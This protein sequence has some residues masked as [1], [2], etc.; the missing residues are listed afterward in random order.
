[1]NGS[2]IDPSP[3]RSATQDEVLDLDT[4]ELIGG[5]LVDVDGLSSSRPRGKQSEAHSTMQR[6]VEGLVEK[7]RCLYN[8]MIKK[9]ELDE[10]HEDDTSFVRSTAKSLFSDGT[11]SWCRITSLVAL[12]AVVCQYLRKKNREQCV[13]SVGHEIST[14]LL[15]EQREWL[16]ENNSWDGFVDF[17]RV[18]DP[19][20]TVRN[21]LM[22]TVAG[23]V[24][25][26]ATLGLL[27]R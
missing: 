1:M 12:G 11:T 15:S 19:E 8:G 2:E 6:V 7:H 20:C 5:F 23:F 25:I 9:L 18:T 17:F 10:R 4:R 16:I 21:A 13:R 3:G 22:M 26:G 27:I 24:G 14:Y